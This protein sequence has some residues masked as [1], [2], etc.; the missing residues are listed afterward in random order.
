V[1]PVKRRHQLAQS[2]ITGA[3]KQHHVKRVKFLHASK[4]SCGLSTLGHNEAA[5]KT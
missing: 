1:P 3:P 2:K 5:E 4:N